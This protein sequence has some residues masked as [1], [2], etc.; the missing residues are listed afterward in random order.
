MEMVKLVEGPYLGEKGAQSHRM[1]SPI[2]HSVV[3]WRSVRLS[4]S[5][6]HNV[7]VKYSL[8]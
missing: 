6:C 2:I 3:D 4:I 1:L 7:S 8:L 5:H